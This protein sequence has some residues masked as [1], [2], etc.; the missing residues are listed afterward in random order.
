[1][2]NSYERRM[3]MIIEQ[4]QTLNEINLEILK[5]INNKGKKV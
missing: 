4:L 5:A 3:D 2:A 1:M